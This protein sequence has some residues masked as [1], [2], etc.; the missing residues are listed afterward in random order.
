MPA[1]PPRRAGRDAPAIR[2]Y[3]GE[4]LFADAFNGAKF[5]EAE[6]QQMLRI[7]D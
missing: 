6:E 1:L 3:R 5:C 4:R 2:I 7:A